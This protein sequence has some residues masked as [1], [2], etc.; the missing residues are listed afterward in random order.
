MFRARLIG[1]RVCFERSGARSRLW[2]LWRFQ[3]LAG[4]QRTIADPS[5]TD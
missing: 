3:V 2:N 4:P 5:P 1:T